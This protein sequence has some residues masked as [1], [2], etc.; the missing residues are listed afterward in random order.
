MKTIACTL[1]MLTGTVY[2][3][4][5]TKPAETPKAR[6][7]LITGRDVAAHNW[8]ETSPILREHLEKSGRFEVV[9]SE[10]PLVLE[11]S[12]ALAR[13]DLILLNYYNF[14]RP[15]ITDKAKANLLEFV[16]EGKGL[17]SFHFSVRAFE[18]WPEY[19]N[20]IGRVWLTGSGHGPRGPFKV[21]V[22]DKEHPI[23]RGTSDF[24]ADDELYAGL[25]GDAP[26]HALIEAD[27]N[28]TK[29]TEPLA[30]TLKYGDG[31]V[32]NIVLGHDAKACRDPN[33]ARLLVQGTKWTSAT[34]AKE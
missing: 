11:S 6:V 15:T 3:Q 16:R 29:K 12:T 14:Q 21:R 34:P 5:A 17:V 31:R 30:W 26:I 8:R 9:V 1:L 28:F 22:T 7:L 32:F 25:I 23:T 4:V 27:S 19:R 20:L 18:E 2:A 13:Y 10:E 24:E 33:F